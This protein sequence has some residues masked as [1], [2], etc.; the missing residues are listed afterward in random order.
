MLLLLRSGARTE[1]RPS[2]ALLV[3]VVDRGS[4][5]LLRT[6]ARREP[7]VDI[8]EAGRWELELQIG[9]ELFLGE[10]VER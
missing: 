6:D 7:D 8:A 4:F 3:Q 1:F 5:H 2:S 10:V 9:A